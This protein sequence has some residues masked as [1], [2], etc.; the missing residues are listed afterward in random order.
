VSDNNKIIKVPFL[1]VLEK[2]FK[3]FAII[4]GFLYVCGLLIINIHFGRFGIFDIS[5]LNIKYI[6]VGFDFALILLLPAIITIGLFLY[7]KKQEFSRKSKIE[8]IYLF[9]D[10]TLIFLLMT[11]MLIFFLTLLYEGPNIVPF[12][13]GKVIN[14][15][16]YADGLWLWLMIFFY[17]SIFFVIKPLKREVPLVRFSVFFFIFILCLTVY[18]GR[19][20]PKVH[21][22]FAGGRPISADILISDGGISL[23]NSLGMSLDARNYLKG[24][25]IIHETPSMIYLIPKEKDK[26]EVSSIALPKKVVE[27]IRFLM[28]QT[29]KK[30]KKNTD[31]KN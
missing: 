25:K 3:Y 7:I 11:I 22:A 30:A 8:K 16:I 26:E 18:S 24:V 20:H 13:Y 1:D 23:V 10:I 28:E 31:K 5:P 29:E 4:I 12:I 15:A 21:T 6:L 27:G 9:F 17:L 2:S 19:I 14:L